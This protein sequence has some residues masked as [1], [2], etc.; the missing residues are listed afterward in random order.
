MI[1]SLI[2]I[3]IV[4][5]TSF[6]YTDLESDSAFFSI[7]LPFVDFCSLVALALWFVT[8]FHK[9]GITQSTGPYNGESGTGVDIGDS[10]GGGD[11]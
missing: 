10:D 2:L 7:F 6:T 3:S 1:K 8:L 5:A 9:K 4:G 11:C